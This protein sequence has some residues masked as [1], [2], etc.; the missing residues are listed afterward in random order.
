MADRYNQWFG[1]LIDGETVDSVNTLCERIH[2]LFVNLTKD[3]TP[4]SQ[5]DV[6][7]YSACDSGIAD[8]LGF[9]WRSL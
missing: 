3:F 4:L 2:H 8:S 1:H 6:S 5:D 9:N 7:N